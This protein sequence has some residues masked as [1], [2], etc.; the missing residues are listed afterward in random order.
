MFKKLK[1]LS[2]S[3]SAASSSN[4]LSSTS[5]PDPRPRSL[6]TQIETSYSTASKEEDVDFQKEN[7][8]VSTSN[9]LDY[10]HSHSKTK[11]IIPNLHYNSDKPV[12][13]TN[14]IT[15]H[16]KKNVPSLYQNGM[17]HTCTLAYPVNDQTDTL[18]SKANGS[19]LDVHGKPHSHTPKNQNQVPLIKSTPVQ[20]CKFP[21]RKYDPSD[22]INSNNLVPPL[23]PRK[24]PSS[25]ARKRSAT[26]PLH[27]FDNTN[28][29]IPRTSDFRFI[30]NPPLPPRHKEHFKPLIKTHS[31]TDG[32]ANSHVNPP[33][34]LDERKIMQNI[35]DLVRHGWYWGP[36]NKEEAEDKL[37]ETNDG[38]FL[39]RDSSDDRHL[40]T[41]SF[42]TSSK[43][44]HTR[45]D[46]WKGKFSV[47]PN[48]L[49][50]CYDSVGQLIDHA[51]N[52]CKNG[53]F[54]YR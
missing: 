7:F 24:S 36:M 28:L 54:F 23:P 45:I 25:Q 53:V 27:T 49:D 41:I 47:F 16:A 5:P 52:H 26:L 38:T 51:M 6:I 37:A 32:D 10:V 12:K 9:I 19:I 11:L 33:H 8:G 22:T 13:L 29:V 43:T 2:L 34:Q 21:N 42:R 15:H 30:N 46:F 4:I 17:V 35:R 48:C 50:D 40:L 39:V 1:T 44:F 31:L 20:I 14:D 3:R 18:I